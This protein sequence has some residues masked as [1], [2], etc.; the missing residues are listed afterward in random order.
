MLFHRESYK[1]RRYVE[2]V[3]MKIGIAGEHIIIKENNKLLLFN[4]TDSGLYK[5][6]PITEKLLILIKKHGIEATKELIKEED[7]DNVP[8]G[9]WWIFITCSTD[10]S[11]CWIDIPDC[12]NECAILNLGPRG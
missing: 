3:Y 5:I 4:T 2:M 1:Y 12:P 8:S 11:I 10:G 9:C 6:D 7:V